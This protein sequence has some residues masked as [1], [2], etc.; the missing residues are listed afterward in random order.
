M[1]PAS[2]S[3]TLSTSVSLGLIGTFLSLMVAAIL[4]F[5]NLNGKFN[6]LLDAVDRVESAV[7]KNTAEVTD[8]GRKTA[9]HDALLAAMASQ[10]ESLQLQLQRQDDRIHRIETGK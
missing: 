8:N 7:D 10:L 4:Y 9:S 3:I 6:L 2:P 1:P 5:A